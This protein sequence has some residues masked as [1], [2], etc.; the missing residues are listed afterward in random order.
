MRIL[1]YSIIDFNLILV[2]SL[3]RPRP[4]YDLQS[5]ISILAQVHSQLLQRPIPM[6]YLVLCSTVH[7]RIRLALTFNRRENRIPAEMTWSSCR[8][9]LP[10][11]TSLE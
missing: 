10:L 3:L 2:I 4:D 11:C 7:L 6:A 5:L 1:K 8:Y 9:D